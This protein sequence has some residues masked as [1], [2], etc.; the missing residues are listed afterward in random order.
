MAAT[1]H[2]ICACTRRPCPIQPRQIRAAAL[3]LQ[4]VAFCLAAL[5]AAPANSQLRLPAGAT[6]HVPL[7]QATCVHRVNEIHPV[8]QVTLTEGVVS[9][10]AQAGCQ[11][12]RL[13]LHL[14][15]GVSRL[16]QQV[17]VTASARLVSQFEIPETPGASRPSILAVQ[18]AADVKW[19]GRLFIDNVVP[20]SLLGY[21]TENMFLRVARGQAGAPGGRRE[22]VR[23]VRFN[24]A[25]NAGSGN[26]LTLP[27]GALTA[28]ISGVQCITGFFDTDSGSQTVV[29]TVLLET[30][31]AYDVELELAGEI[32]STNVEL[33]VGA[34]PGY[35]PELNFKDAVG[36]AT[37]GLTYEAL[38]ITIASDP[39][40]EAAAMGNQVLTAL[41]APPLPMAGGAPIPADARPVMT[42]PPPQSTVSRGQRI[43]VAWSAVPG[44]SRYLLEVSGPGRPFS[45][46]NGTSLDPAALGSLVIPGATIAPT[47]PR[48]AAPGPYQVR[49]ISLNGEG[50]PAGTFSDALT[51]IVE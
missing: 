31:T 32:F 10:V 19:F 20:L 29:M 24:G 47:V 41:G 44:V 43:T 7:G 51:L 33:G 22:T 3:M 42:A 17:E 27:D 35:H 39:A 46:P 15:S 50:Q 5:L 26:C 2:A 28:A 34:P 48:D 38:R 36:N 6:H 9:G 49:V 25:V 40:A 18:I 16:S 12:N 11:A 45:I 23:E 37:P 13:E 4:V 8:V 21:V 14:K 1:L 30:G